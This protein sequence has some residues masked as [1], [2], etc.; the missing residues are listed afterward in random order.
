MVIIRRIR[1]RAVHDRN[2][3]QIASYLNFSNLI[4][5]F[6]NGFDVI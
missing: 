3:Q 5:L 2:G 6:I 1:R 4:G